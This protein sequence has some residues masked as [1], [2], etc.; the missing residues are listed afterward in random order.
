MN[1]VTQKDS[2]S[3]LT[4]DDTFDAVAGFAWC[5][6]LDVASDHEQVEPLSDKP[7]KYAFAISSILHE[8]QTSSFGLTNAPANSQ[9]LIHTSLRELIPNKHLDQMDDVIVHGHT[10]EERLAN[11]PLTLRKF[12]YVGLN[13]QPTK[14]DLFEENSNI[15]EASV[16][17]LCALLS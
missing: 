10:R 9:R 4:N 12:L 1:V 8:M 16:Y 14:R 7:C 3:L 15:L 5:R 17:H 2:F 13:L 11:I 6:T